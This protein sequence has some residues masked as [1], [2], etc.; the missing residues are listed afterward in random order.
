MGIL[1]G[2]S[3]YNARAM[4]ALGEYYQVQYTNEKAKSDSFKYYKMSAD[5]GCLVGMHWI[6]EF[7]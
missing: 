4:N 1:C 2:H 6:G 3:I 5:E 7:Y